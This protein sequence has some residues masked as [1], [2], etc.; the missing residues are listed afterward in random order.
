MVRHLY[1]NAGTI[2]A[3]DIR[4]L[5]AVIASEINARPEQAKAAIELLDEG[6]R[7]VHRALPQGSDWRA[8]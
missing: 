5:S 7:A 1:K 2:M 4:M 3:A 8:G 6:D